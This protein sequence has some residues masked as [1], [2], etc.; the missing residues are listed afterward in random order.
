MR[1]EIL[2]RFAEVNEGNTNSKIPLTYNVVHMAKV[3]VG[4][5]VFTIIASKR[6]VGATKCEAQGQRQNFRAYIV[7]Q[8]KHTKCTYSSIT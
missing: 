6:R 1:L 4:V 7:V 5:H 8:A 2:S 3:S